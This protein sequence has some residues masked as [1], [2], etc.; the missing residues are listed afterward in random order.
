LQPAFRVRLAI[1][2]SDILYV[3][4]SDNSLIQKF[5]TVR[6]LME[7]IDEGQLSFG[8][9]IDVDPSDNVYVMESGHAGIAGTDNRVQKFTSSG[10]SLTSWVH[11]DL[12]PV[13]GFPQ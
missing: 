13:T 5:S 10:Q 8:V 2:P 12:A 9:G 7:K 11:L 1:D 3:T 6:Q 4:E